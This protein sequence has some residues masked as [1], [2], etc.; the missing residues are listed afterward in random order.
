MKLKWRSKPPTLPP[1]G[2]P[3]SPSFS[4]FSRYKNFVSSA[5]HNTGM[6]AKFYYDQSGSSAC[7]EWLSS[8]GFESY[9][10]V[11]HGGVAFSL[12][13]EL[14]GHA[15]Y[16]KHKKIG[17]TLRACSQWKSPIRT[18][19]IIKGHA[20]ANWRIGQWVGMSA[21]LINAKGSVILKGKATFFL[22]KKKQ[23]Q[24]LAGSVSLPDNVLA[25][26]YDS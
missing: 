3:I 8:D 5:H 26:C 17:I 24:Y 10:S 9:P 21:Y 15:V 16:A 2:E 18:G 4:Q 12:L 20:K 22:P 11:I 23:L 14:M 25:H 1:F 7:C 13:D 6:Q 19:D